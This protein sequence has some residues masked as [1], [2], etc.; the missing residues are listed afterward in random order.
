M[1]IVHTNVNR[2]I[3]ARNE[4]EICEIEANLVELP[5]YLRTP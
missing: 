3:Y 2:H 1:E 4:N 5:S